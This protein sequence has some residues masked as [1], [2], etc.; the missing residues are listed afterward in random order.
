MQIRLQISL[1][2]EYGYYNYE[3]TWAAMLLKDM[4]QPFKN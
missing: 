3:M 1:S 2:N 4:K